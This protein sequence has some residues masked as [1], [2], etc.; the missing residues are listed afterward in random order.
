MK[1]ILF[2]LGAGFFIAW[3]LEAQNTD[4]YKQA[5]ASM[6]QGQ[7]AM[8]LRQLQTEL[9]SV[10]LNILMAA[11]ECHFHLNKLEEARRYFDQANNLKNS[12]PETL[13]WMARVAHCEMKFTEAIRWYKSFLAVTSASNPQRPLA[14]H[15][16]LQCGNA[17]KWEL[18]EQVGYIEILQQPINTIYDEFSPVFS[19]TIDDRIYFSSNRVI[20]GWEERAQKPFASTEIYRVQ[21][22]E[23][24]KP[25]IALIK[26]SLRTPDH[27]VLQDISP[28]GQIM[29]VYRPLQKQIIVD[30]FSTDGFPHQGLFDHHINPANG[31]QYLQMVN[32]STLL[33]SANRSDSYGGLDI[34]VMTRKDQTWQEPINLG[35]SI[36]SPYNEISP[37]LTPD[38]SHLFFSSDREESIGGY[39]VFISAYDYQTQNWIN[40]ENIYTPVNSPSDDLNFKLSSNGHSAILSSNRKQGL[41]GYDLYMVYLTNSMDE[42]MRPAED[43]V[44][45][46]SMMSSGEE[47]WEPIQ[48]QRISIPYLLYGDDDFMLTALNI[49]K[50]EKII[51]LLRANED[52][53]IDVIGHTDRDENDEFDLFFSIKRA[54][55]IQDYLINN[56]IDPSR[57]FIMGGGSDFPIAK[58]TIN[59]VFNPS[60]QKFNRRIDFRIHDPGEKFICQN[61]LPKIVTQF[62]DTSYQYFDR[63]FEGLSYKVFVLQSTV[64]NISS[65]IEAMPFL[66]I[67]KSNSTGYDY[68]VGLEK[69]F[70]DANVLRKELRKNGVQDATIYAYVNGRRIT[71]DEINSFIDT[72]QDLVYFQH[73]T[74]E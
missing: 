59:N 39:D 8:A 48:K 19:P 21:F 25:D 56:G 22:K 73:R 12:T 43:L 71:E 29:W 38:Q 6:A 16:I 55:K 54:E 20:S 45:N 51:Q 69:S 65:S 50:L 67:E 57:I 30:T 7:Y 42:Y 64:P 63:S 31:D 1:R 24:S 28:N 52:L 13:F 17:I 60:G 36:N 26:E 10:N 14:K 18:K 15:A 32:D 49:K 33:F 70:F 37:F 61:E 47:N 35:P 66:T 2:T 46:H 9:P 74:E 44:F 27:D 58:N 72:Y 4:N 23:D 11:G 3:F 40:P 41:G 68:T 5:I 34:Y 62:Q 53:T